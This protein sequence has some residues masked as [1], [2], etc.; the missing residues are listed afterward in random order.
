M[1]SNNEPL[2]A[3]VLQHEQPTPGGYVNQWLDER[4]AEQDVFRIDVEERD[5]DARD[6]DL[7]VSLGSEFA[8]FDDSI[9]W[10]EREKKLFLDAADSDVPVLG[11]CFGGQLL[12]RV[13]GGRSFRGE[14]SE[15][16]WLPVRSRDT[17]LV[18]EGPW[19]Q[20]HFD[21]FTPPPGANLIADSSVGPQ[22]FTIG[23]SL[24]LQF[25]PEVTPAIVEGWIRGGRETLAA[26]RVDADAIRTRAREDAAA[27][28][29]RAFALFDAI[30][31]GW[32]KGRPTN[33]QSGGRD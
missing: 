17:S 25:H 18:P 2:R 20:W 28:R 16:G 12:A 10:L 22:A 3:L 15:I 5:R 26:N 7:I 32:T 29:V 9:P 21:T 13:L 11:I 27:H 33:V 24:G 14:Q 31:A 8:A 19:F 1:R 30:A 4:G 6:Y 23:N